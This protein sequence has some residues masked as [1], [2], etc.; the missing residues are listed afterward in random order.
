MQALY[1]LRWL[2][3]QP[4][5]FQTASRASIRH[6]NST[7][8]SLSEAVRELPLDVQGLFEQAKRDFN[9]KDY[10]E[11]LTKIIKIPKAHRSDPDILRL[12]ARTLCMRHEIGRFPGAEGTLFFPKFARPEI[13]QPSAEG[14][15]Q[16]NIE[17]ITREVFCS[18]FAD[19]ELLLLGFSKR[20]SEGL[21]QND[22]GS[23]RVILAEDEAEKKYY[24][25]IAYYVSGEWEKALEAFDE[26]SQTIPEAKLKK[27]HLFLLQS[28]PEKAI[29]AYNAALADVRNPAFS[30]SEALAG[31]ACAYLEQGLLEKAGEAF[32]ESSEKGNRDITANN[33]LAWLVYRLPQLVFSAEKSEELPKLSFD[34]H[35]AFQKLFLDLKRPPDVTMRKKPIDE[36][37]YAQTLINTIENIVINTELQQLFIAEVLSKIVGFQDYSK[38][39]AKDRIIILPQG[40][41]RISYQIEKVVL[42][43]G[44]FATGLVPPIGS[45]YPPI[46]IFR[47]TSTEMKTTGAVVSMYNNIDPAGVARTFFDKSKPKISQWLTRLNNE[48]GKKIQL[49][50]YSQGAALVAMTAAAFPTRIHD[51]SRFPSITLNA[52]GS[53]EET[54]RL[55]NGS[56]L[57]PCVKQYL[58]RGDLVSRLGY[59]LIG[60]VYQIQY[61]ML[62]AGVNPHFI[63]SFAQPGWQC[64]RVDSEKDNAALSRKAI[65]ILSSSTLGR[66]L[67]SHFSE[68]YLG[69]VLK[70]A[71]KADMILNS[72]E[73]SKLLS[74]LAPFAPLLLRGGVKASGYMLSA[75]GEVLRR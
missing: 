7:T 18:G 3:T 38:L 48:T 8:K 64:F 28:K 22:V 6:L 56:S 27:G 55:W 14:K 46:L 1:Q 2:A 47:G 19:D 53:D 45:Q 75:I 9:H 29:T 50:G 23:N 69:M 10:D 42:A 30:K 68:G 13:H 65:S 67:F 24:K 32:Q 73:T 16:S 54:A 70:A 37:C 4:Q 60:D 39:P 34:S 71:N 36:L 31:I 11:T 5:L 33:V 17:D 20:L 58:V 12:R 26:I 40:S 62:S 51:D 66:E 52:A 61:N 25:A 63:L 74:Y 41:E 44:I 49:F 43:D 15:P 21:S 57:K 59:Q 72:E 35:K